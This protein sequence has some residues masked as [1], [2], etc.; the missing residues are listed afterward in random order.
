[1]A[2]CEFRPCREPVSE[3]LPTSVNS[4]IVGLESTADTMNAGD[5]GAASHVHSAVLQLWCRLRFG[6]FAASRA[7]EIDIDPVACRP[8]PRNRPERDL[9]EPVIHRPIALAQ[10]K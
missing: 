1:V 10:N 8:E 3:R 5:V 9:H 2:L 7:R 6:H 4:M